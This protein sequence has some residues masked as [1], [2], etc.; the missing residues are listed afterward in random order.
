VLA[1]DFPLVGAIQIISSTSGLVTACSLYRNKVYNGIWVNDGASLEIHSCTVS[2]TL[3]FRTKAG[4]G[5]DG[6]TVELS[7]RGPVTVQGCD[8]VDNS[9][10]G[11]SSDRSSGVTIEHCTIV[12]SGRPKIGT[13]DISINGGT[14]DVQ[15][16]ENHI[17]NKVTRKGDGGIVAGFFSQFGRDSDGDVSK[18][19]VSGFGAGIGL[20]QYSDG[21]RVEKN[22][23]SLNAACYTNYGKDNKF[24]DNTCP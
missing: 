1:P 6:I 8:V 17:S 11:V 12:N 2:K 15:V 3:P 21:F 18:N 24:V 13:S 23:F 22:N 16:R 20:G 7:T 14:K 9:G 10:A 19:V 4:R 5:N